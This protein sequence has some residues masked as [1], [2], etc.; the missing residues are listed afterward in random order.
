MRIHK[1]DSVSFERMPNAGEMKVYTR[2]LERGLKL[3]DKQVDVIIHNSSAPSVQAENTGIGSLFSR[4][5]FEKLIPFLRQHAI[6]GIQQEPVNFRKSST[7]SPYSPESSAKNIYMIPLEKLASD[8]YNNLLSHKTFNNIVKK[9]SKDNET[10]YKFVGKAYDLALREAYENFKAGEFLKDEFAKFKAEKG[11]YLE[12]AAI[13]NI[14]D[15][16]Y[17]C[18]WTDWKS[19]DKHLFAPRTKKQAEA[20]SKRITQLKAQYKDEI[21]FYIFN[22]M[23]LEKE[24]AKLNELSLKNGIKIIGDSPVA[25]PS[26][27]EWLYQDLFLKGK[28]LGCPPDFFSPEGQR[29]GFMYF[30]PKKIFNADGTFGEAGKVLQK[31]Y[32]D[33]FASSPGG[34][35]I[36]H[37][38][39]LIDPFLY[40]SGEKM[41]SHNSGRIYSQ[42]GKYKKSEEEFDNIFTKI[43]LPA[44]EKYGVKKS[45]IICEDLGEVTPPTAKVMKDL[46][47]SGMAVT[48]FDYRGAETPA[49]NTIVIGTHDNKSFLEYVEEFFDKKESESGHFLHKT[50]LLGHDISPKDATHEE[51]AKMI[52]DI[53][54]DK[55]KFIAA[56]FAE[57]FTSPARR[58]QIF[59]TD[60]WGIPKTYNIPGT[61]DGNWKL[62]IS[63]NFENDYYKAVSEGKAPNL[64]SSILTAL[65]QRGLDKGNEALVQDLDNSAKIL[66]EK[67]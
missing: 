62:R 49:K 28:A 58:V 31:K 33:Y 25:S 41:M 47:L 57:L 24:N 9:H 50:G 22:Q 51:R 34:L 30:D 19:V 14:L 65:R 27:D 26:T 37:T 1:I 53:R 2:S 32:E 52:E 43:I 66:A 64:A 4:T 18:H 40:T 23:I 35:R 15:K 11:E 36:D 55:L 6:K 8:E 29:W 21:D 42:N 20:A 10:D 59:F 46:G 7:T 3:L 38:I 56:S 39:G 13:F 16:E 48:Q 63:E 60:F 67:V 45:D 61:K 44:A 54:N 17:A 5:T 12:K